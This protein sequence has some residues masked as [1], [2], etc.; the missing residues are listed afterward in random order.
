MAEFSW[1]CLP[2]VPEDNIFHPVVRCIPKAGWPVMSARLW[3]RPDGTI[4]LAE[5]LHTARW[6]R[7]HVTE[8]LASP[9]TGY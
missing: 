6:L 7:R 9:T 8:A 4:K 3:C 5:A 1:K 2:S